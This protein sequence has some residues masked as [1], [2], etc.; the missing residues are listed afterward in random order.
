M[1]TMTIE[2]CTEVEVNYTPHKAE[3]MTRHYPGTPPYV[4][5][6]EVRTPCTRTKEELLKTIILW[7]DVMDKEL[8]KAEKHTWEHGM[9]TG[10]IGAY[11]L[12]IPLLR[13][14]VGDYSC[15]PGEDELRDRIMEDM[16][17]KGYF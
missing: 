5:I 10:Y 7:K 9:C 8:A 11:N 2:M 13:R 17:E 15:V 14:H 12:V 6:G 1:E 3:R 4:D 16:E